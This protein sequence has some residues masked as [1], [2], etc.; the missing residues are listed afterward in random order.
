M[1]IK[2][3]MIVTVLQSMAWTSSSSL[4]MKWV[5]FSTFLT[6]LRMDGNVCQQS[7]KTSRS[8]LH[9]IP[10]LQAAFQGLKPNSDRLTLKIVKRDLRRNSA[11]FM[12][13]HEIW[14]HTEI[15]MEDRIDD[16]FTGFTT[17]LKKITRCWQRKLSGVECEATRILIVLAPKQRQNKLD[18]VVLAL[19]LWS[20]ETAFC[21]G[22]KK[23]YELRYEDLWVV[24]KDTKIG[25][26]INE[27]SPPFLLVNF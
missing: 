2:A 24:T 4:Q 12:S 18:H 1:V 17:L 19:L 7:N 6:L 10:T 26:Y 14:R 15:G 20:R 8:K 9:C 25:T 21:D 13:G 3:A 27:W 11:Q 23:F 16:F 5:V 22:T